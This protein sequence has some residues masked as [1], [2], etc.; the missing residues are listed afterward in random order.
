MRLFKSGS[1]IKAKVLKTADGAQAFLGWYDTELDMD[2][3]FSSYYKAEDGKIRCIP[4]VYPSATNIYADPECTKLLWYLTAGNKGCTANLNW[5]AKL[6][7]PPAGSCGEYSWAVV[8]HGATEYK[9]TTGYVK[10]T[11]GSCVESPE[12]FDY[13]KKNQLLDF[14]GERMPPE[15]FAEATTAIIE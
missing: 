6:V 15:T 7:G 1:R 2:C 11:D 9:G 3:Q 4:S 10:Q 12:S 8:Y 13:Y 14:L 5:L